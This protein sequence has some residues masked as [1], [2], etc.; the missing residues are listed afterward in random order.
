[1][2]T[3]GTVPAQAD[4]GS[5]ASEQGI[6][7]LGDILRNSPV[8]NQLNDIERGSLPELEEDAPAPGDSDR[9]DDD[10]PPPSDEH[11]NA[12]DNDE[13]SE[14][15][16]DDEDSKDT[17]SDSLPSDD[18]IDWAY[19]VPVKVDGEVKYFTLEELR[20]GY[21]TNQHLSGEGRKLGELRK[22]IEA[23]RDEKLQEVIQL[24][25]TLHAQMESAEKNL[26]GQYHDLKERMEKAIEDG[27]GYE[28]KELKTQLTAV[29]KEYWS[30]REQKEALGAQ[31]G[32]QVAKAQEE[33]QKQQLA[34]FN[35]NI[36]KVLPKFDQKMAGDIRTFALKE[37]VPETLL[38]QLFDPHVIKFIN[39]YRILK[40]KASTG[41][42]KRKAA[43]VAKQIP[44]RK[45]TPER[46]KQ[47]QR[48]TDLRSR[49]L[50]GEGDADSQM[51]FL[52]GLS[53]INS[54]LR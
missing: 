13:G 34:H 45:G 31:V 9:N 20:K 19:K 48:D 37:G 42:E 54:K 16:T 12:N 28:A 53:K 29:Q 6:P 18:D 51:A 23:E 26:A 8:L 35:E 25:S 3:N 22:Q 36:G 15:G 1:M 43:P 50:S 39:D 52:R 21:A 47:Q 44:V 5:S 46:A 10:V 27:D 14:E 11:G 41:A 17:R 2:E 24:G 32:E 33:E 30:A 40:D 4:Q 7:N 38:N 49:V